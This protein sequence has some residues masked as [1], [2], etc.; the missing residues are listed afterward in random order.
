MELKKEGHNL[1]K[2]VNYI[3]EKIT[4]LS[5]MGKKLIEEYPHIIYLYTPEEVLKVLKKL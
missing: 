5:D 1:D 4:E 3:S 2:F